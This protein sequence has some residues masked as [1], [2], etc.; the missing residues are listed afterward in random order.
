[1]SP[2]MGQIPFSAKW[3]V[4]LFKG[5]FHESALFPQ[6]YC[7][8]EATIFGANWKLFK[9]LEEVWEK[10]TEAFLHKKGVNFFR[11]HAEGGCTCSL[12][13]WLFNYPSSL[14]LNLSSWPH[15]MLQTIVLLVEQVQSVLIFL[16]ATQCQS[17]R[18][19][20]SV[21]IATATKIVCNR[22]LKGVASSLSHTN[23]CQSYWLCGRA[24][25]A[26]LWDV[27]EVWFQQLGSQACAQTNTHPCA[28]K[29]A[30]IKMLS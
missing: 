5:Q 13:L 9:M 27:S 17:L 2:K 12:I 28:T 19:V 29:A 22:H 15:H 7:C 11:D 14:L 16:S 24:R 18:Y 26:S 1:M 20:R 10:R 23:T 6:G 30:P 8:S 3:F 21:V 4:V 25:A